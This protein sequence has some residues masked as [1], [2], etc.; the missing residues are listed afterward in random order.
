MSNFNVHQDVYY[1]KYTNDLPELRHFV[2]GA[3]K[4]TTKGY[5]YSKGHAGAAYIPEDRLFSCPAEAIDEQIKTLKKLLNN[6]EPIK[7]NQS[8]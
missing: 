3:I 8:E 5:S 4:F 2:I 1:F 6:I 7:E